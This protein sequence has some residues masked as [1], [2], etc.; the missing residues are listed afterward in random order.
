M[1]LL[2]ELVDKSLLQ[3]VEEYEQLYGS[4]Y[5]MLETIREHASAGL[6]EQAGSAAELRD[7]AVDWCLEYATGLEGAWA[8]PERDRRYR[9]ANANSA[10]FEVGER[11][12]VSGP[13]G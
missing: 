2:A 10:T 6:S 11:T 5:K 12:K 13:S 4:R 7:R 3:P 8:S 1:T 9:A